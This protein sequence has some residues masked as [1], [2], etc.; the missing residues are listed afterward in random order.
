MNKRPPR[1]NKRLARFCAALAAIIITAPNRRDSK[2]RKPLGT[3]KTRR[4]A[5]CRESVDITTS[6]ATTT[7][8]SVCGSYKGHIRPHLDSQ[9]F[10]STS[11]TTTTTTSPTTRTR[12]TKMMIATTQP[13]RQRMTVRSLVKTM[14]FAVVILLYPNT[15]S[16]TQ[17]CHQNNGSGSGSSC[18]F[19]FAATQDEYNAIRSE[20]R[21]VGKE[22]QPRCRSRWSPYH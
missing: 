17:H 18:L 20:E 1:S 9:Y 5:L 22:C 3:I 7:F 12:I 15:R 13:P 19:V 4:R 16:A 14:A 10:I 8:E 21:R 11:I 6:S 2:Q